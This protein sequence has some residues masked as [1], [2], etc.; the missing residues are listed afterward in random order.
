MSE[1]AASGR[2]LTRLP[3]APSDWGAFYRRHL[4]EFVVPFWLQPGIIDVKHGG[5]HSCV[6]DAGRVFSTDKYLW[7]QTRGL[8]TFSA[9][10]RRIERR[11]EWLEIARGL[12]D[13]CRRFGPDEEGFWRFRVSGDG[14]PIEGATSLGTG[15]FAI[16]GLVE[17]ARITGDGEAAALARRTFRAMHDRILSGRPYGTAPYV[18]PP[19]MR[20]HGTAMGCSLAF[21][22]L[23]E[24]L[25][26]AEILE[27]AAGCTRQVLD[28]FI[29]PELR[30][31]VEYVNWNGSFSDTPEG[32]TMVPGHGIESVWF[33]LDILRRLNRRD[34]VPRL[35][36]GLR[37][38]LERGWDPE[39][40]GIL[41]GLDILGKFPP[42]W[43]HSTAKPWWPVTE[44]LAATLMAYEADRDP[45]WLEDH[46]RIMTWALDRYPVIEHGEWRQR[47]DRAGRPMAEL[48]A[49]PVKDPFHLPRGL[50]TGIETINRLTRGGDRLFQPATAP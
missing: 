38:C 35:L 5:L 18:L 36:D 11:P 39:F 40:G 41:L 3:A 49:L 26:D 12:Y 31:M 19:G 27:A 34:G 8:W 28:L 6:D 43:K 20:A 32:R 37:W 23:G 15:N 22:E 42:Y 1:P 16:L 47:L 25:G 30:G 45:R 2:A 48:I 29:R 14:T 17:Y 10:Y 24:F 46:R 44:A 4:L 33:Q 7:S 21:H 9:L 50:I 13:F